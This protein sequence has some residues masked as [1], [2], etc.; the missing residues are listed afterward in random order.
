MVNVYSV[1]NTTNEGLLY[2]WYAIDSNSYMFRPS[3]G[4]RHVLTSFEEKK[5]S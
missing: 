5:A 3:A 2:Q 1:V 4:Y